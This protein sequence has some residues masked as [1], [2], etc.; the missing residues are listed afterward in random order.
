MNSGNRRIYVVDLADCVVGILLTVI[1]FSF[2]SYYSITETST[3]DIVIPVVNVGFYL[4]VVAIAIRTAFRI[5]EL[6]PWYP[7]WIL[8]FSLPVGFAML[9]LEM[10]SADGGCISEELIGLDYLY[11]SVTTFTTLGYGDLAPIGTCRFIA[12]AQA[13]LG[14]FT[15]GAIPAILLVRR[16]YR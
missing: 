1:W 14:L 3:S 5:D 16:Q 12:S 13:I 9:Y 8:V 10:Q 6:E 4:G 11:F 15:I 2:L 7:I